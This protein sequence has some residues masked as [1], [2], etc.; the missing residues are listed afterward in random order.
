VSVDVRTRVLVGGLELAFKRGSSK[1]AQ[2]SAGR[3]L[4]WERGWTLVLMCGSGLSTQIRGGILYDRHG[5]VRREDLRVRDV[6]GGCGNKGRT[7]R[8][9]E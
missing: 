2:G 1:K 5:H 8:M 7:G 6:W 3:R 9:W 4:N